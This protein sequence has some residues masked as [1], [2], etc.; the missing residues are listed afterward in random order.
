MTEATVVAEMAEAREAVAM[1]EATAVVA[2]A[3]QRSSVVLRWR[4]PPSDRWRCWDAALTLVVMVVVLVVGWAVV[5]K[6]AVAMVE[7]AVVEEMARRR[8][9][10]WRW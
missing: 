5:A 4:S 3:A 7:A 8:G 2:M 10:R 9:R 6:E 1:V